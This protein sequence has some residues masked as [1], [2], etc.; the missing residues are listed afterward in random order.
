MREWAFQKERSR[1][2][3]N[4]PNVTQ[5]QIICDIIEWRTPMDQKKIIKDWGIEIIFGVIIIICVVGI[6]QYFL[7]R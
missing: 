4:S 7:I 3:R 2:S 6:I 1:K 5:F